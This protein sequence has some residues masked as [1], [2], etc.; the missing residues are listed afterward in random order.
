MKKTKLLLSFTMMCLSIAVLCFGVFSA[1]SV[2]YTVSGTISYEITDVFAKLNAKVFKVAGQ[3]SSTD[4]QTNVDTLATI[5]LDSIESTT[6]IDSGITIAEYDTTSS[7][8]DGK[9]ENISITLDSEYMTY[10]VVI[11]V[12]NLADKEIGAKLTDSTTY[13]NLN[14]AQKLIQNSIEK[15]T[16]RNLVVAF[17]IKDKT[18]S[19]NVN[20]NYSV[21]VSYDAY[22][23]N[24][25]FTI[26]NITYTCKEGTTWGEFVAGGG[27]GEGWSMMDN[28]EVRKATGEN[29]YNEGYLKLSGEIVKSTDVL[30]ESESYAL[31]TAHTGGGGK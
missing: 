30:V 18:T 3:T 27:L 7:T 5:A 1:I 17:S 16:T 2:S 28:N 19:T 31:E 6:Y 12:K 29:E 23:N 24:I 21:A 20:I 15:N 14:T 13:T 22:G 10:Y 8:D 4:M 26:N 11:N 9:R 25:S